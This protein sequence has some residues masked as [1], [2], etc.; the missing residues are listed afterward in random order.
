MTWSA[1][2]LGW[3]MTALVGGTFLVTP[4]LA[5]PTLPLGVSVPADRIEDPAVRLALRGYRLAVLAV[6]AV[7]LALTGALAF[8]APTAAVAVPVLLV[9]VGGMVAFVRARRPVMA[10]KAAED[11]YAGKPVRMSAAVTTERAAEVPVRWYVA[12][13]ALLATTTVV[14]ALRYDDLPGR[15]PVHWD[16]SGTPDGFADTSPWTALGP[17]WI[18]WA[19]LALMVVLAFVAARMPLRVHPGD[20][21]E[22]ALRRAHAQRGAAQ[23]V[24]ASITLATTALVCALGLDA[25]L[26]PEELRWSAVVLPLFVVAVVAAT[27]ESVRRY[28]R[29]LGD[30]DRSPAPARAEA[31]DD[32]R[33][34]P[35]G[36][37]YVNRDDPSVWVPK[38][39]G[40][41]WTV[42]LGSTG[43]MALTAGLLLVPVLAVV[44]A[45]ALS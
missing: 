2:A 44:L 42:N 33:F 9:T 3:G 12:S 15:V 26:H 28:R 31:P 10:A 45:V 29:A 40:I 39:V 1:L 36:L 16:L 6:T 27:V 21:A 17:V 8:A 25:W 41:G 30:A 43:G 37:A 14:G 11:W 22:H 32:D 13:A 7:A 35:G 23:W 18:G 4:A 20:P 34:W 38:R 19:T 5:R 24:L